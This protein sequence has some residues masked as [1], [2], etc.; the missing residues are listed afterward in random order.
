M[1]DAF[2]D[3]DGERTLTLERHRRVSDFGSACFD[4][5]NL[6]FDVIDKPIWTN[7]RVFV[8]SELRP[9]AE[10]RAM[11]AFRIEIRENGSTLLCD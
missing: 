9:N 8:A 7:N 10:C 4:P 5:L 3:V 1:F 6:C 11:T 2:V